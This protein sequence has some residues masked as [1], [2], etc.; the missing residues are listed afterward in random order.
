M[1]SSRSLKLFLKFGFVTFM[2]VGL[3]SLAPFSALAA[4]RNPSSSGAGNVTEYTI[5]TAN[6]FPGDIKVG[7]DGNQWFS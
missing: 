4:T 2:L 7:F 6:S 1:L 3:L 5:P